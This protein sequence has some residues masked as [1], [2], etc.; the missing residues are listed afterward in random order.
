MEK[1]IDDPYKIRELDICED[2]YIDDVCG[3]NGYIKKLDEDGE[4][5][6]IH[7]YCQNPVTNKWERIMYMVDPEDPLESGITCI[8]DLYIEDELDVKIFAAAVRRAMKEIAW[9]KRCNITG[10]VVR[11]GGQN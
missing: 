5:L 6:I 4:F 9:R 1:F 10:P 3:W 2:F 8:D 11:N 7:A